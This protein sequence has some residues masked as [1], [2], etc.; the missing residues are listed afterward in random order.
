M[1]VL[2]TSDLHGNLPP[3][4]AC[5]ILLLGGDICPLAFDRNIKRCQAW[6]DNEFRAWLWSVPA[7]RIVAIAG[8]HDFAF[9]H[10][11]KIRDLNLPWIYLRDSGAD[12][13]GLKI[14][15]LPWVPNLPGWAFYANTEL[16]EAKYAQIPEGY[17]IVLSHGPP[18]GYGDQIARGPRVGAHPAVPMIERVKPKHFIC[19]HIH[20]GY[21]AYRAHGT[22][23]WNVSF[24]DEFYTP[25][26]VDGRTPWITIPLDSGD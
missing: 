24:V 26:Q 21:G 17:D 9:E 16:L 7:K 13:E 6:L 22:D 2:A 11:Q 14:W 25:R 10:D 18:Y 5:D 12:I 19:G 23:I 8:N 15:G 3:V 4:P 20:E 1:L